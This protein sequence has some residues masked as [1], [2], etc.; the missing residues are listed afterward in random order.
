MAI[1]VNEK[2]IVTQSISNLVN[3]IDRVRE[4]PILWDYKIPLKEK[5]CRRLL[6]SGIEFS[7][8]LQVISTCQIIAEY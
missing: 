6:R 3:L 1:D 8:I 4:T 7:N 2:G 5:V